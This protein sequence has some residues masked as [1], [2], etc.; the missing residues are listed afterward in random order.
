MKPTH[1][2]VVT[3]QGLVPWEEWKAS[4]NS[5]V[6][7]SWNDPVAE[8]IARLLGY[9]PGQAALFYPM[10]SRLGRLIK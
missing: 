9:T 6:W 8:E 3:A 4:Q 10:D 7:P 2:W 5:S 1:R